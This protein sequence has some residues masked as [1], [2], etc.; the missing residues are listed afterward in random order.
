M[1]NERGI[2]ILKGNR[3]LPY[4][5]KRFFNKKMLRFITF[6]SCGSF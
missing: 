6:S 5:E 3:K 1:N 4:L 2:L